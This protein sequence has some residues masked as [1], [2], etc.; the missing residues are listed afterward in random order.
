MVVIQPPKQQWRQL[1]NQTY[2]RGRKS[3]PNGRVHSGA[4]IPKTYY[5]DDADGY[6]PWLLLYGSRSHLPCVLLRHIG[7]GMY[8]AAPHRDYRTAHR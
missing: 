1:R 7:E 6:L 3:I 2:F 4:A 5:A 8:G